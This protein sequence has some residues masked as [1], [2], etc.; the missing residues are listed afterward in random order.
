[1]TQCEIELLLA[2][3]SSQHPCP[4]GSSEIQRGTAHTACRTEHEQGFAGLHMAAIDQCVIR[5]RVGEQQGSGFMR[6]R[7]GCDLHAAGGRGRHLFGQPAC[8]TAGNDAIADRQ[9]LRARTQGF[10]DPAHL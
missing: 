10:D 7:I 2:G 1:M 6:G 4:Q 8:A 9:T 5:G 3:G